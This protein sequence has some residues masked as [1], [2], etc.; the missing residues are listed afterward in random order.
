MRAATRNLW[1]AHLVANAAVLGLFYFWLGILDANG[2]QLA[3]TAL[4]GALLAAFTLWLHGSAF[5]YFREPGQS[6]GHAYRTALRHLP[7]LALIVIVAVA[8]YWAVSWL[9]NHAPPKAAM[10]AS[11]L[12]MRLRRP[13]RPSL[14]LGIMTGAIRVVEW[15]VIPVLLLPIA[16]AAAD[17]GWRGFA[18]RS[19]ALLRRLPFLIACPVLLLLAL[20]APWRLIH[21]TPW[22][23]KLAIEMTSFLSRWIL[24]WLLFVTAWLAVTVLSGGGWNRLRDNRS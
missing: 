12:T 11:W 7:A 2:L 6:L 20:Y 10:T 14:I 21:W 5:A 24:A 1:L 18:P 19:L 23:G 13:V 22:Q 9:L 4:F 17:L 3:A 15:F 16:A 8:L